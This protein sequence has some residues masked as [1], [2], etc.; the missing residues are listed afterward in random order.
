[1]AMEPPKSKR[2][3]SKGK[4]IIGRQC[5]KL[6][7]YHLNDKT[8]LP[9]LGEDTKSIFEEGHKV[10][11]YARMKYP[12]G[13]LLERLEDPEKMHESS[14]QAIKERIP[15]FE[16]GMIYK[17][18]YALPDIL[19]PVGKNE[20]DLYEVK[21]AGS[22]KENYIY[23]VA[24]QKYIYEGAGLKLRKCHLMHVD[25]SYVRHGDIDP[26][27]LFIAED[28]TEDADLISKG[29][30]KEV[31]KMLDV[32]NGPKPDVK[33]GFQCLKD[34]DK[35]QYECPLKDMCW[36]FIPKESIFTYR[37]IHKKVCFP[38]LEKGIMKMEDMPE[39]KL[40]ETQLMQKEYHRKKETFKSIPALKQ[41]LK[42]LDYPVYML[43]FETISPVLPAYDNTRPYEKIPFQFS[44]HKTDKEGAKPDH[45]AYLSRTGDKSPEPEVLTLLM[46]K[47]GNKGTILAYHS[48]FEEG[49]IKGLVS[50]LKGDEGW[51][52]NITKRIDD[53]EIPFRKFMYYD[54]KQMGKSSIKNVLPAL[55]G[56]T[57]ND[58][59]IDNG[60]KA[61]RE[62]Y[63]VT[64]G[65]DIDPSDRQKVYK[66]LE[67]YCEQDTD[68]MVDILRVLANA[69]K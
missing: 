38:I 8:A 12:K 22:I 15:L 27:I 59:E 36:K 26:E 50:K 34:D 20:W 18:S 6:L 32:V 63:R 3:I 49:V 46:D 2:Y 61:M 68:G 28:L 29:V 30:E 1:M 5:P 45:F 67:V 31:E 69:V 19:V 9:E 21:M 44:L 10:G 25:T 7:W 48:S 53:L 35:G 56:R 54:P 55:T 4:Y 24:Y 64:F 33:I 37:G 60:G 65:K 41:F 17:N 39:D 42:D 52:N 47:L 43:D 13:K 51:L 16:S 14:M 57:Y 11:A 58:L 66:D 62:Y 23:D 40:N